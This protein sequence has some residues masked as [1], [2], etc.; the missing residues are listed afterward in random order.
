MNMKRELVAKVMAGMLLLG[1]GCV[2]L[3]GDT[4][5]ASGGSGVDD[6]DGDGGPDDEGGS[7][8]GTDDGNDSTP[9]GEGGNGDGG[10][11]TGV[12]GDHALCNGE[13]GVDDSGG[14]SAT[15]GEPPEIA[16]LCTGAAAPPTVRRLPPKQLHRTLQRIFDDPGVPEAQVLDAPFVR[17]FKADA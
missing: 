5:G 10:R 16:E 4:T 7:E 17:G 14:S 9:A 3:P 6:D 11:D 12:A 13:G 8:D 1:S 2:T 15:G